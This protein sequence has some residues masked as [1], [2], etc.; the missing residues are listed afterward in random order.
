MEKIHIERNTVQETLVL[1]LFS[2]KV[3]SHAFPEFYRDPEAE[4]IMD[5]IDYDFGNQEKRMKNFAIRFGSLEVAC[6]ENALMKEVDDYLEKHPEASVINLGC[7]LSGMAES[8]DNG[9]CRIYNLDFPDVMDVR[10]ELMP[11]KNGRTEN[12]PADLNDTSWFSRIEKDKGTVFIA[13]GVFYYFMPD[14]IEKLFNAMAAYFRGGILVFDTA[15]KKA[16]AM[17]T[18][19]WLKEAGIAGITTPFYVDSIEK[20]IKPWLR[21]ADVTT[22]PYMQG[23]YKLEDYGVPAGHRM[24]AKLG[25]GPMHMQ[26]VKIAF[27]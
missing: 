17:I 15:G 20:N 5:A 16:C 23:Y 19:T 6:R 10:N 25:D 14:Q 8:R 18:K 7:G 24:L 27:N 12:I 3:A 2:R 9:R 22:R 26:I 4:R 21:N 13:S 11:P 1:P